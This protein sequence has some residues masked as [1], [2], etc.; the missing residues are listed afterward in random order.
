MRTGTPD[1]KNLWHYYKWYII[2]GVIV[3]LIACSLI[4][5]ALGLFHK[6]PDLQIACVSNAF[7]PQ[8]TINA[9][10]ETFRALA[11]DYNRDG[12]VLVQ[13]NQYLL[14]REAADAET[15]QSQYASEVALSAD[16]SEGESYLFLL[17]D[18]ETFQQEYQVLAMPDGSCPSQADYSVA[19]KAFPWADFPRLADAEMG[20]FTE[21]VAG[22]TVS[23]SNQ[24]LLAG[25]YLG[26]RCFYTE[27][28]SKNLAECNALWDF[29]HPASGAEADGG[30]VQNAALPEASGQTADIVTD[31]VGIAVGTHLTVYNTDERLTLL[32]N[33]DT[34]SAD[35]LYYASWTAGTSKPYENADGDTVDLYDAQLYLLTKEC[36]GA[37][38]AQQA[39]TDWLSAGRSNYAVSKE[40]TLTVGG[41]PYTVITYRFT[42][43]DNPYSHGISAFGVHENTAVCAELTCQE[44]YDEDLS[45]MLSL[46]LGSC[47]YQ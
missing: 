20:A 7:L 47:A 35:G 19:D 12:E 8:D 33:M 1:W 16:I 45:E 38:T 43:E 11:G 25:F 44:T 41:Q 31:S 30:A 10:Q 37:E 4:G 24:E 5:N 13:V 42:R 21:I 23:G 26:R 18:P 32:H 2:T 27:N 22:Q 3:L 28:V 36:A 39:M 14:S 6:K 40:E 29:L 34:L 46:F 9:I 15:A 17:E